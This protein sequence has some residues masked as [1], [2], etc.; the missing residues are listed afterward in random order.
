MRVSRD[1][2]IAVELPL[3]SREGLHVAPRNHLMAMD[4]A[5]LDVSNGDDFS[6]NHVGQLVEISLHDVGL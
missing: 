2:H 5:K 1:E 3:D 4:Y 6:L